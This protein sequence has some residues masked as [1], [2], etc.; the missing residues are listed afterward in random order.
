MTEQNVKLT[1]DMKNLVVQIVVDRLFLK[2]ET[3]VLTRALQAGDLLYFSIMDGFQDSVEKMPEG[4]FVELSELNVT[5]L[6][7]G[8]KWRNNFRVYMSKVY[9]V[10]HSIHHE[11]MSV[12]SKRIFTQI[13]KESEKCKKISIERN[14]F[15]KDLVRRLVHIKTLKQLRE[16][17]PEGA[18]IIEGEKQVFYPLVPV[19]TDISAK[20]KKVDKDKQD[21][22]EI[23]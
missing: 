21:E 16:K 11:K 7:H 17:F 22:D 6:S 4:F 13:K 1:N 8:S 2:K 15:K 10:P 19:F 23:A 3:D 14:D 20:L 9:R 12:K 18:K 5:F